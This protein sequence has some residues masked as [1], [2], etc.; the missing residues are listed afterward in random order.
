MVFVSLTNERV[1]DTEL[2]ACNVT[3]F[4]LC[5]IVDP[6]QGYSSMNPPLDATRVIGTLS[7]DE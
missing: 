7:Q 6:D 5:S 3:S 1:V 2:C 4:A